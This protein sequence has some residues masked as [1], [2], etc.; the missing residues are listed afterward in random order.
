MPYAEE[1]L[2]RS[3]T[4]LSA[5]GREVPAFE[6]GYH[7]WKEAFDQDKAGVWTMPLAECIAA[8]EQVMNP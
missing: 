6:E 7:T 4:A 1:A 2:T 5:S 8:M 3:V